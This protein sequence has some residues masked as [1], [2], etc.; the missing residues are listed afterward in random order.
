MVKHIAFPCFLA[1]C[2]LA[3]YFG[4]VK[5]TRK[6]RV[7]LNKCLGVE[8]GWKHIFFTLLSSLVWIFLFVGLAT[9]VTTEEKVSLHALFGEALP[10]L[11][12]KGY[13]AIITFFL[14]AVDIIINMWLIRASN[15][16]RKSNNSIVFP[17]LFITLIFYLLV[18]ALVN[19][20]L[21][22]GGWLFLSWVIE[23]LCLFFVRFIDYVIAVDSNL[24][25]KLP[26][27][28]EINRT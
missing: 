6:G 10:Q 7:L 12:F 5:I 17:I 13:T 19:L 4:S 24:N 15:S 22:T 11:F 14:L 18:L 9:L 23:M 8:I 16:D 26:I 27:K 21:I 28:I 3:L 1:L 20:T 25:G 2:S